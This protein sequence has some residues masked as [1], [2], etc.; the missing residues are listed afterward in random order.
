MSADVCPIVAYLTLAN[1]TIP[2][3]KVDDVKSIRKL[4]YK[5]KNADLS[6]SGSRIRKTV[7]ESIRGADPV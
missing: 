7:I 2:L 4:V 5:N 1:T 6:G 3:E